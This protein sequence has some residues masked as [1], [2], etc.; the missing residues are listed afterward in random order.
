M[1][2][3]AIILYTDRLSVGYRK[4]VL[5]PD[6]SFP[7]RKGEI[8]VLIGPNGAGKSTI[9]KTITSQLDAIAGTCVLAGK[10]LTAQTPA[11]ISR[12]MSITL[13]GRPEAEL[14]TVEDMVNTGR[15]P[16]TGRLGILSARD[17]TIV[18]DI[19]DQTG[20]TEIK[21]CL[22][23]EIS[24][25]QKQRTMLAR[26]LCQEPEVLVLDEPTSYL[27][28]RHKMDFLSLLKKMTRERNIAV[29]LSLHELELAEKFADHILCIAEGRIDCYGDP[30]DILT[31]DYVRVLYHMEKGTWLP[32]FGSIEL[33]KIAGDPQVFVIGGGG[34]GIPVYRALQRQ[35]TPF[36]AGILSENDLDYPAACALADTVISLPAFEPIDENAMEKARAVIQTCTYVCCTL[37]SFGSCN[38]KNQQLYEYAL[39]LGLK[40]WQK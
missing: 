2:D 16:Y 5:I 26:A 37:R 4:K 34:T 25:G 13:T 1:N 20:L 3:S 39:S 15:Y 7:V 30:E 19:L 33:E 38:R 24:D 11:E 18:K 40:I 23:N 32:S 21:D 6:I 17:H 14:M 28:I 36:A 29:I 8:L 10:S 31:E 22:F 35:G 27:D 9:L 12:K